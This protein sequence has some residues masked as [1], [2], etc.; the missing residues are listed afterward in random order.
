MRFLRPLVLFSCA[1]VLL[2]LAGFVFSAGALAVPTAV[3]GASSL[4]L[5]LT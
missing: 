3:V 5:A 2:S 1:L 4:F